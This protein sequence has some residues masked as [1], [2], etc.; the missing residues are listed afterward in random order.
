LQ[1]K[2]PANG[3]TERE[4]ERLL[5]HLSDMD[6]NNFPDNCGAGERE[7][8]I[9]SGMVARRCYGLAHGI[10]RSGAIR[11]CDHNFRRFL[12]IFGDF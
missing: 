12:T 11:C 9:F 4:I 8:R 7:G 5:H 6:S 10:G 2:L 3:W 1:R